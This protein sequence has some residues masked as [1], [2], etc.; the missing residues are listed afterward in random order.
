MSD[1]MPNAIAELEAMK[2]V[3]QAVEALDL[4]SRRRVLRWAT[5]VLI[6]PANPTGGINIPPAQDGASS[7]PVDTGDVAS[8]FAKA[9]PSTGPERALAIGYW[10]QEQSGGQDFEAFSLNAELKHLGHRLPNVT[11][12][13]T[14][15]MSQK[16]ALVIQTRK[17]GSAQQARKLYR[18]TAEGVRRVHSMLARTSSEGAQ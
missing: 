9:G 7:S 18:L 5:D 13:L 17:G 2:A 11:K 15:L 4:A 16:P 1:S 3:A 8:F 6:G 12:T 14:L 10:L